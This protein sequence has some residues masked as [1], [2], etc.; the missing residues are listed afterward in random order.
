MKIPVFANKQHEVIIK[1]Y[2]KMHK[3]FVRDVAND[4][5]WK[6][7]LDVLNIIIDYHNNYRENGNWQDWL[8]IIPINL[9]VMTN[10]FLSGIETKKNKT[11]VH[12]YRTVINEMAHDVSDK[13]DNLKIIS[14]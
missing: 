8:M 9:A 6:N 3:D 10:G 12:S 4:V 1:S 2:I 11:I 13:L 7:Y 5:R 14:E